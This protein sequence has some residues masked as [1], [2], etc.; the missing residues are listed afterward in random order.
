MIL[1]A[2]A[3]NVELFFVV[4]KTS[5]YC[6]WL[7]TFYELTCASAFASLRLANKSCSFRI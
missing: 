1:P 5:S 4:A 7:A 6:V 2:Y 3:L